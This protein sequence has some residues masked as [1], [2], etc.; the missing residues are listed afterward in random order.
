MSSCRDKGR[1]SSIYGGPVMRRCS[2][3]EGY[4]PPIEEVSSS[5]QAIL[6]LEHAVLQLVMGV[7]LLVYVEDA[8]FSS[9]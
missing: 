3:W 5:Q 1:F 4:E 7:L 2:K 6:K 9:V 8:W